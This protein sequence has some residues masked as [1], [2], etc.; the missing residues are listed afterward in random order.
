MEQLET[1]DNDVN[2]IDDEQEEYIEKLQNVDDDILDV[3]EELGGHTL[4]RH[5]G[6]SDEYLI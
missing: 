4:E 1:N 2:S 6:K 3:M 5:L